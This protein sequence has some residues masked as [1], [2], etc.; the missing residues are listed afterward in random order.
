MRR[1]HILLTAFEPFGPVKVNSSW[2]AIRDWEGT[3]IGKN[4]IHVARL[5]VVYGAVR[6]RLERLLRRWKPGIVLS[7]GQYP[8]RRTEILLENVA[9]NVD[10]AELPDNR[11]AKPRGG[12]VRRGAPLALATKLPCAKIL[13]A[14]GR[15]KIPARMSYFAGTY[16][17]NHLFFHLMDLAGSRKGVRAAGFVHLPRSSKKMPLAK[18]KQ[19]VRTIVEVAAAMS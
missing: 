9:L 19:G 13:A 10:H 11:G 7:L 1:R 2:E 18:L 5:P 14:L 16:L 15:R 4:V 17:C 6:P 8:F 12:P 3:R